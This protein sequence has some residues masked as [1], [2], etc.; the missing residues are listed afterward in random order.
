MSPISSV[1]YLMSKSKKSASPSFEAVGRVARALTYPLLAEEFEMTVRELNALATIAHITIDVGVSGTHAA[2]DSPNSLDTYD[3]IFVG[4][5]TCQAFES[6]EM[7]HAVVQTLKD[8]GLVQTQESFGRRLHLIAK[9]DK[10]G[11]GTIVTLTKEG[12]SFIDAMASNLA[13]SLA[14]LDDEKVRKALSKYYSARR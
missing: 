1:I 11:A 3:S 7:F 8:K 12:K 4:P 13:K 5:G 6:E 9:D 10:R 14:I 2:I